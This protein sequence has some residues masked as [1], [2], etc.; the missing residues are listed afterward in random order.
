MVDV[1][2]RDGLQVVAHRAGNDPDALRAALA[3]GADLVEA[4]VYAFRGRIEVRHARTLGP[5]SSRRFEVDRWR[6]RLIAAAQPRPLLRDIVIAAG[7]AAPL[8]L[9]IKGAA[10]S[11]GS[12]GY[13]VAAAWDE[14]RP[15]GPLTVSA[16]A[17]AALGAFLTKPTRPGGR[18]RPREGVTAVLSAGTARQAAVVAAR[19]AAIEGAG[20]G[21]PA[22]LLNRSR[23]RAMREV[24]DTL[25]CWGLATREQVRQAHEWGVTHAI[26]DDVS[27]A[28]AVQ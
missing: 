15:G 18:L 2:D 6:P 19:A 9:D 10:R 12:V 7:S 5:W 4:D 3:A 28:L 1:A 11:A 24:T 22:G 26:V 25:F 14:A 16:Q 17:W 13:Q 20:I 27:V 21:L 8:M 23:A